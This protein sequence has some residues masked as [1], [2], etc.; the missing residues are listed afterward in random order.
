MLLVFVAVIAMCNGILGWVGD[1]TTL[2][3]WVAANT[4]YDGFSLEA[5][6]DFFLRR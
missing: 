3:D 5:S 6:L 2:N 4:I 1:W